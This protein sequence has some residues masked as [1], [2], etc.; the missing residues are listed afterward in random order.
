MV[1]TATVDDEFIY[2]LDPSAPKAP[3]LRVDTPKT[4]DTPCVTRKSLTVSIFSLL[5][6]Q[7]G[8]LMM[9]SSYE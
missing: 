7:Y 8:G 5:C 4:E 3:C 2:G 9:Q 1:S 6:R